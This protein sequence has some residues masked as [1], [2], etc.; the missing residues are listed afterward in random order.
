VEK[1]KGQKS[2]LGICELNF[3]N[4]ICVIIIVS[5]YEHAMRF[6]INKIGK[7]YVDV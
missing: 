1:N 3:K 2:S 6:D 7:K 4:V 5:N